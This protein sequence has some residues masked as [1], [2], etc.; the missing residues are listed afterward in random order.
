MNLVLQMGVDALQ[1]GKHTL[2]QRLVNELC[3]L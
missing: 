3:G 2:L 1:R